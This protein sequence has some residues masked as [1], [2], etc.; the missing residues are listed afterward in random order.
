MSSQ[1][2]VQ[3]RRNKEAPIAARAGNQIL[4]VESRID[5]IFPSNTGMCPRGSLAGPF[6][7]D[8]NLTERGRTGDSMRVGFSFSFGRPSTGQVCKFNGEA[9]VNF[10]RFNP[11][12]GFQYLGD[13][14]T[15]EMAVE[16]FRKNYESIFL[17]HESLSMDAPSPWTTKDSFVSSRTMEIYECDKSRC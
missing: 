14:L 12:R 11:E 6:D 4:S 1:I 10:S 16:I 13:D 9:I 17:L 15:N 8:V 3:E 7:F 2:L 5:N